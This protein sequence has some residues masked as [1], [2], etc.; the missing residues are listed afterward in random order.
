[1]ESLTPACPTTDRTEYD[2]VVIGGGPAGAAA[3]I[4]S[5]RFGARVLLLE[6]GRLPRQR[7]CGEFVSAESLDLLAGL[8]GPAASVVGES[9]RIAEARLFVDGRVISTPVTPAASSIA[10]FDLDADSWQAAKDCGVATRLQ[11]SVEEVT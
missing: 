1:M 6:R 11:T 7:V 2:L 3:A 10:R 5:A 9:L 4:T 8:L